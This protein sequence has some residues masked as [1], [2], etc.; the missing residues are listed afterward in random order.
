MKIQVYS[1]LHLE[2]TNSYPKINPVT[3]YL[4]LAGDI[5][6]IDKSN[7]KEFIDYCSEHWKTVVNILGNHEFYHNKKDYIS[8]LLEYKDFF[9][10]Y[11]NVHLLENETITLED[12]KVHGLSLIHI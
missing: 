6:H 11:S 8:L 5:G 12:Y 10:L 1:D 9:S 3:P 7:F 4:F 2:Y